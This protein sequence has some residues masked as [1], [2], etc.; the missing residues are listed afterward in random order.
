MSVGATQTGQRNPTV[1]KVFFLSFVITF[2]KDKLTLNSTPRPDALKLT[3]VLSMPDH[4]VAV[5]LFDEKVRRTTL[6]TRLSVDC[7]YRACIPYQNHFP[8]LLSRGH[9]LPRDSPLE[10]SGSSLPRLF[11]WLCDSIYME[12]DKWDCDP[13]TA[14]SNIYI[15][16]LFRAA[17]PVIKCPAKLPFVMWRKSR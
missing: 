9:T 6:S 4:P 13:N 12:A 1:C 16:F 8:S 15:F 17:V 10:K 5:L 7:L 14:W 2:V 3:I 11:D